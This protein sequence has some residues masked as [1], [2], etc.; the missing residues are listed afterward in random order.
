M[1]YQTKYLKESKNGP[2][3]SVITTP[4]SMVHSEVTGAESHPKLRGNY[5]VS[6]NN[7]DLSEVWNKTREVAIPDAASDSMK[8][9]IY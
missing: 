4:S 9:L 8:Y 2:L 3:D 1:E 7:R 6:G 5:L